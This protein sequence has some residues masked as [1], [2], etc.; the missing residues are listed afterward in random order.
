MAGT[1]ANIVQTIN[2]GISIA[3]I[4]F[5][6]RIRNETKEGT[7]PLQEYDNRTQSRL[8][9]S[10]LNLSSLNN[11][12]K[13][14]NYCQCG[15]D[16]LSNICTEEQIIKGC[17]DVTP[18]EQKNLLRSLKD[19]NFC[20]EIISRLKKGEKFSDIF[21]LNYSTVSRMALGILI[22]FC[23]ILAIIVLLFI[24]VICIC[25]CPACAPC[26]VL[27]CL[28]IIFFVVIGS[29]LVDLVI[30]II[31]LVN[32]YK[33]FTAGEFLDFYNDCVHSFKEEL[34]TAAGKISTLKGNM[35][36]LVV[37]NS[38]GIVFNYIGA[39]LNRK[40]KEDSEGK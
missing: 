8:L 28:P 27:G 3:I 7:D 40:K 13:I 19:E 29:G 15:E 4:V 30:F 24:M 37:L 21:T 1:F 6:V 5:T 25:L 36:A 12:D 17:Y 11:T 16:M 35:T 38:I 23:C 22:I 39:F 18:N 20:N 14:N 33:G 34:F 10:S 26:I 2:L 31:M 32:F 9:F